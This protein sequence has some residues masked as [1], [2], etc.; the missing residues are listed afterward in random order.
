MRKRFKGF[1]LLELLLAIVI[2]AVITAMVYGAFSGTVSSAGRSRI[3]L[4]E[5]RL[6]AFLLRSFETNF[7]TVY[8]D[9][10]QSQEVY[11]FLGVNSDGSEGPQDTVRFC[12]TAPLIG[13]VALPGDV[14]E[15]RYEV[16]DTG[17]SAMRLQ[18]DEKE[19][20]QDVSAVLQV[21]ETPLLAGN[22]QGVDASTA[23]FV[24]DPAYTS[25][26]W[27]VPVRT[28]NFQYFD[29]TQW[30]D[31][32]D[33]QS[34]GRLPWAV[35][36]KVNFAKTEEQLAYEREKGFSTVDDP[37]FEMIIPIRGGLGGRTDVRVQTNPTGSGTS[38]SQ[39]SSQS[40]T[41]TGQSRN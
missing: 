30:L 39:S 13:G 28:L 15:V 25:P 22:V 2:L 40:Q 31:E 38:T 29:G 36:I 6:R 41:T 4:E 32:W 21:T 23:S 24:V 34:T 5:L 1:T 20:D 7:T 33:S 3:A 11:R 35:W 27:T 16:V 14:K 26:N 18:W 19:A 12:S 9:P 17:A 10:Q 8:V 37:D